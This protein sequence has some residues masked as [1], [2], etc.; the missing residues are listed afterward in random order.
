MCWGYSLSFTPSAPTD[1][2]TSSV[3]GNC[4]HCWNLGIK[5]DSIHQLAPTIPE[6]VFWVYQLTFAVITAALISG[7]FADRMKYEGLIV[8]I[9]LWHTLVYCPIAHSVWSVD[10]FLFKVRA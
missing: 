5:P 1:A 9:A 8:F 3:I 4:A 7:A 2:E 6:T 10:G